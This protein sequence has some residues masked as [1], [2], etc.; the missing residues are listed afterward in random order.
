MEPV[1]DTRLSKRMVCQCNNK[2]YSSFASLKQHLKTQAHQLWDLNRS[3]REHEIRATRLDNENSYLKRRDSILSER[4]DTLEKENQTLIEKI[5][6]L[7][8]QVSLMN[9]FKFN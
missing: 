4:N 9:I 1:S 3:M 5:K 6:G 7:E 2:E 8:A